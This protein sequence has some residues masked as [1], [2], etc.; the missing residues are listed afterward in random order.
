MPIAFHYLVAYFY[1]YVSGLYILK[2]RPGLAVKPIFTLLYIT[3]Y[4][5]IFLLIAYIVHGRLCSGC[6]KQYLGFT[7]GNLL[8]SIV[9]SSASVFIPAAILGAAAYSL[10]GVNPFERL[11]EAT[12]YYNR[13]YAPPW[14]DNVPR[15]LLPLVAL[16][17]W[18][19][20]GVG[21]FAFVQSF[22]LLHLHRS[23]GV[24]SIPIV[25]IL[26]ILLYNLPLITGDWDLG[27]IATLGVAYPIILY[28]YRNS[29][30]LIV[31]YIILYEMPVRAAFLKGWG[32]STLKVIIY[33]Q[34]AW[35]AASTIMALALVLRRRM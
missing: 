7:G 6:F 10:Y 22:P 31:S 28:K 23:L 9:L 33:L 5:I 13:H 17:V 35:G 3:S 8:K 26:F 16:L 19:L 34:A 29:L 27:D 2:F 11:L 14:F 1:L 24:A 25:S 32:L 4:I 21:W 20:A 18:L 12:I 30:G 15:E